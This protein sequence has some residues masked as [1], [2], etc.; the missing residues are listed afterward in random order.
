MKKK[1]M[2][3]KEAKEGYMEGPRG[4]KRKGEKDIK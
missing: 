4:R 3:L 1:A 2:S